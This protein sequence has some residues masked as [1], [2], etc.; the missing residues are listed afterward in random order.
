MKKTKINAYKYEEL[1]DNAKL[2]VMAWL[3][4]EPMKC[5]EE[6]EDGNITYKYCYFF[7]MTD[8]EL[9][10]H[11]ES[12]KYLFNENGKPLYHYNR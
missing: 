2:E 6:D 12:N 3:D 8:E 4:E 9:Q 11:C 1:N 10:N 7:E 5:E